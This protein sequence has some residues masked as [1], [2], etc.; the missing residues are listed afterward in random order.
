AQTSYPNTAEHKAQHE[1]LKTHVLD[2]QAKFKAGNN[3]VTLETMN[4]LKGWLV[5]HIQG[6]DQKYSSHLKSHGIH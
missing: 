6:S 5:N 3:A 2:I 4:F 1:D